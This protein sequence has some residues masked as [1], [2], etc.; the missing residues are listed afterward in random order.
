M[1]NFEDITKENI[2]KHNPNWPQ[3]SDH[4]YR[5]LI[6]GSSGSGKTNALR[7]LIS[8]QP[9]IDKIYVYA[10][11]PCEAKYQFLINKREDNLKQA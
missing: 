11:D 8:H 6:T 5:I 4:P 2:N 7:N 10:K 9:D 1:I 3:I